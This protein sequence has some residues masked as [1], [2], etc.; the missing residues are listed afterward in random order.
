MLKDAI[1]LSGDSW[2]IISRKK[3]LLGLFF[4]VYFYRN[5][6]KTT[7]EII[8]MK[9]PKILKGLDKGSIGYLESSINYTLFY[10]QDG[11]SIVSGYNIKIFEKIF[12][13]QDFI[14]VNRS[15]IIN[16]AFIR[17]TFVTDK[18]Y[19]VQLVNGDEINI[20]RRRLNKIREAYPTIF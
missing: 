16:V 12:D 19:A 4:E 15:K 3:H 14:K 18:V 8:P 13:N 6:V 9:T 11:K 1:T 20:S 5:F 10:L 2:L 7:I 17:K